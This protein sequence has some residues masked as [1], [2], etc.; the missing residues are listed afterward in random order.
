MN[1]ILKE[2]LA[3][4]GVHGTCVID[5]NQNVQIADLPE[6]FTT[7]MASDVSSNVGRMM[8]MAGVK[9]MESQS[10]AINYDKFIILALSLQNKALLLIICAPGSNSALAMTTA[11]MLAPE[12]EKSLQ[13]DPGQEQAQTAEPTGQG[14][15]SATQVNEKT[16]QA[17]DY[18]KQ[19]LFE[20]I[21]PI[22]EMIYDDCFERWTENNHADISRI[23]ELVGCISTEMDN[24]D[25]FQEF[26]GKIASLL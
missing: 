24:P 7:T 20:T 8:Q 2:I 4:P 15:P 19:S 16:T 22:A 14:E 9:G 25:L 1:V 21:G 11:R 6:S 13:Q 3:L 5:E 18:L 23:F 12:I 17:L 26:K 10:I